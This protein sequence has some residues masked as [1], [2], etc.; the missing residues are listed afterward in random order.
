MTILALVVAF[1]ALILAFL[2]KSSSSDLSDRISDLS[3]LNYRNTD[4]L[5]QEIEELKEQ[6][7]KLSFKQLKES[8]GPVFTKETKIAQAVSLHPEAQSVFASFHL[9]GCSSCA[10]SD[11]ETIEEGA[12]AHNVDTEKLL[13]ALNRLN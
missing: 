12:K 5:E 1:L 11:E 13:E 7:R 3:S 6:I 4:R 9:G 2:A 10:V 8:G